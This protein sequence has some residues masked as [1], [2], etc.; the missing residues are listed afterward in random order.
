VR[1]AAVE[2]LGKIKSDKVIPLLQKALRDPDSNVVKSANHALNQVKFYRIE[3][4]KSA[5]TLSKQ[6]RR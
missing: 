1:L 4:T 6:T 3:G 2:A 5:K